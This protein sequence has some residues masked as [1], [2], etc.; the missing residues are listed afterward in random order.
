MMDILNA[1]RVVVALLLSLQ[2][3]PNTPIEQRQQILDFSSQV[4]AVAQQ[5]VAEW[6]VQPEVQ[7]VLP[8]INIPTTI[9]VSTS[10]PVEPAS[11]PNPEPVVQP[12][13][14]ANYTV[15]INQVPKAPEQRI[16]FLV[17][18]KQ[19]KPVIKLDK[20]ESNMTYQTFLG[21]GSDTGEYEI[22]V[23][24]LTV[25]NPTLTLVI[26]GEKIVADVK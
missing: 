17:E 2:S 10:T 22:Y 3:N 6:Q 1:L 20:I 9:N 14:E 15:T 13:V 25:E 7:P 11:Q 23:P 4:V 24:D 18:D 5:Y 8:I 19:G 12:V 26:A 21:I 16:K